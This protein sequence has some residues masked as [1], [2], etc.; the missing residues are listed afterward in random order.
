MQFSVS[1]WSKS[2]LIIACI[3][4]EIRNEMNLATR[5]PVFGVRDQGRLKPVCAAKEAW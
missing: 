5:K 1:F 4:V 3:T 2:E